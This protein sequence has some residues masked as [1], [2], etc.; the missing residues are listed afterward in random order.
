MIN[1]NIVKPPGTVVLD[2][3]LFLPQMFLMFRHAFSDVP[4]PIAVKLCH[5]IGKRVRLITQVQ[6]LL[7]GAH[8]KMGAK[9]L[10]NLGIFNNFR[11]WLRISPEQIDMSKI[12]KKYLIDYNPFHVG[13][14]KLVNFGSQTKNSSGS[15][16]PT[17]VDIF[18][19]TTFQPLG[20]AAAQIFTRV[21]DWSRLAH[22]STGTGVPQK[23]LI[24]KI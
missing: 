22:T 21:R 5:M 24:A 7:E 16:W 2:G 8:Q 17:Q 3:L 13:R 20:G 12:G 14:K 15:Y 6:K 23:I 18:R 4:R 10:Q 19:E 1:A 9:N 11:L